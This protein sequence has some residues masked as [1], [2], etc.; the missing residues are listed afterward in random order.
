[1]SFTGFKNQPEIISISETKLR[2]GILNCNIDVGGYDFVHS[3]SRTLAGGVEIYNKNTLRYSINQF[4]KNVL[5]NIE[6]L[7][8]IFYL[9]KIS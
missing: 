9:I 3:D 7:W 2:E 6:H 8:L 1:M 5:S 4:S